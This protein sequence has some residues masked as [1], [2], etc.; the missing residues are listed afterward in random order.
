MNASIFESLLP[1]IRAG[2]AREPST[3]AYNGCS[4]ERTRACARETLSLTDPQLELIQ[5]DAVNL[6]DSLPGAAEPGPF[7]SSD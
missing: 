2:S 7:A 4:S 1:A 5:R 6:R 3:P